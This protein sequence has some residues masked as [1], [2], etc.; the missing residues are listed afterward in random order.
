MLPIAGT[1]CTPALQRKLS[2]A[3]VQSGVVLATPTTIKSMQL[4]FIET[5]TQIADNSRQPLPEM[6]STVQVP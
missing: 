2:N 4:R 3:M 1:E 5:L 6:E